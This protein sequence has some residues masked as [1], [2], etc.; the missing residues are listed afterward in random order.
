MEHRGRPVAIGGMRQQTLLT[1][2]LLEANH[3]VGVDR[4]IDAIW[5]SAPPASAKDQ[6]RICVSGLRR[7]FAARE[8]AEVIE[9][10]RGGYRIW[11]QPDT[12]D[13]LRFEELVAFARSA[14][15][16]ARPHEAVTPLRSAL[17]LWT[18]PI[19]TGLD[20]SLVR[21]TAVKLH[22]E[23]LSALEDRF[24]VE[25]QLGWHRRVVGELAHHVSEHPFREKLCAQLMLALYQSGRRAE[26][27]ESFRTTRKR[28]TDELGIEPGELLRTLEQRMLTNEQSLREF[29]GS[30]QPHQELTYAA[31]APVRVVGG[32]DHTPET[33]ED[34]LARLELEHERLRAE[35]NEVKRMLTGL[36]H[37]GR[38]FPTHGFG[39]PGSLKRRGHGEQGSL[40]GGMGR[41][42]AGGKTSRQSSE[43]EEILA[44]SMFSEKVTTGAVDRLALRVHGA[45]R[46]RRDA[47]APTGFNLVTD[48]NPDVIVTAATPA[49]IS[50]AVVFAAE[51][52]MA[53]AVQATGHGIVVPADGGMLI[54]TSRMNQVVVDPSAQVARVQAGTRWQQVIDAAAP[55]GLAPLNGSSPLVGVVG[56]TLGG[57]LGVLGRKYG[58]AAD[59]VDSV[60]VVTTSG[61]SLRAAPSEHE[62]LF[63]AIRGGKGNFGVVTSMEIALVPVERLYGGGLYFPAS[64][65]GLALHAWREWVETVPEEMTSSLV[66]L[67]LPDIPDVPEFLRG[68]LVVHVRISFTGSEEAG[69]ELLRPLRA[70]RPER[71]T[72]AM[73]PYTS[74][75]EIHHDPVHPL[76]YHERCTV[77][78]EFDRQ[79]AD[80]LIELAGPYSG[81]QDVMVELRHLGGALGRP[82]AVPN[83]VGH[84]DAAFTLS[85]IS[86]P[87]HDEPVLPLVD[88][89][90]RWSTGLRYLNFLGGP[91]TAHQTQDAFDAVT[92]R[93]LAMVKATYD[94]ANLLRVNHNIL[95]A[96]APHTDRQIEESA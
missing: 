94:P 12:L 45:V 27:L 59:N 56:Y 35:H 86:V 70:L 89:M 1:M 76:P 83:A 84:R 29:C 33:A 21:A 75:A 68:R 11:A 2:L 39:R 13:W 57:G 51:H 19:G 52:N 23:R 44:V 63:W 85:T 82:P 41:H 47:S 61:A 53:V 42:R 74:M 69:R 3:V 46:R 66:L 72:V 77:L 79:A 65:A 50:A 49:D 14:V 26:A 67:R 93:R 28:F 4:L 64:K 73:M 90:A 43:G 37:P 16:A 96:V 40:P 9:T 60:E 78:R 7:Q 54:D 31:K 32:G 24:D 80:T 36:L 95:P 34:R 15:A 18:G 6:V 48:H 92:Y 71:D 8:H 87:D 38:A 20:S 22:E 30:A 81:W 62:D 10:H 17:Q 25:L 5:D 58:Y 88:R 91:S 55:H